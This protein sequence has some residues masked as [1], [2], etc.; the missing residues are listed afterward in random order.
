MIR[1]FA[2]LPI[3]RKL[4]V[5]IVVPAMVVFAVAMIA[6]VAMN[7]LHMRDDLQWSAARVARIT[8][9]GTIEALRSGNDAAAL[10]SM[11]ALRDEWLA[12]DAEVLGPDGRKLAT[13]SRA[14]NGAR[15][16]SAAAAAVSR[17]SPPRAAHADPQHPRLYLAGRTASHHRRRR[18]QSSGSRG[19][20][21]FSCRSRCC[22]SDWRGY[23]LITLAAIAAAVLAAYWLA[24]RLQQQISGPIVNL[25]HTMQRVS[26]E[27]DYSLRVERNS[28]D[29]VGSLIDGFN[30]MLG[31]IRHRDSRLEKYRQFLEQQVEERTINLG[32]ANL[33]LKLAIG[34]A[35]RAKEAAERASSAKSEFLARMSHEIRTPMNGVMGMSELLA[36]DRAHSAA[37]ASLGNHLAFRG[38]TAANHQRHPGFLEGRGGQARARA[39]RIRPARS[40]GGNHRDIR[41]TSPRQGTGIGLRGRSR[42]ARHGT[43]RSH[44]PAAGADQLRRQRHQVHGLRRSHRAGSS[45]R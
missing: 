5:V 18:A 30:Q 23:L 15:L 10:K 27:E 24:A 28:Q 2:D 42:R 17:S 36:V 34:E 26:A 45:R 19:S 37:A 4:R 22:I 29:E 7:L 14:E 31:Q 9:A 21:A 44:A 35:T 20:S 8:G 1:W 13:Y 33:E 40:R 38:S 16:E 11:G 25:A 12:S 6:H 39:G 32:N 3:E 41:G 43:R